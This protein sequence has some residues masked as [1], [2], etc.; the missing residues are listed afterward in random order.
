MK[1]TL[2]VYYSNSQWDCI[3]FDTKSAKQHHGTLA[4]KIIVDIEPSSSTFA[5][6]F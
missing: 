1:K 4:I 5:T 6:N 3:T 2:E